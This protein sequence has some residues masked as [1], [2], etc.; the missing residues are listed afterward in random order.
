MR[1][2]VF[3][4]LAW[5]TVVGW[6]GWLEAAEPAKPTNLVAA[7]EKLGSKVAHAEVEFDKTKPGS[8]I[9]GVNLLY[10]KASDDDLALLKSLTELQSLNLGRTPVTDPGLA[11]LEGLKSL[12][13][14]NLAGTKVTSGGLSHIKGL[15]LLEVSQRRQVDHRFRHGESRGAHEH[16]ATGHL[17]Q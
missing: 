15:T 5:L 1:N 14:L 16:E 11:N 10:S 6:T 7:I 13:T 4:G 8:P 9:V 3:V 2:G 12:R 17:R